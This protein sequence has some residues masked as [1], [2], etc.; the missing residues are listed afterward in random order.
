MQIRCWPKTPR[1]R[2]PFFTYKKV[3]IIEMKFLARLS[4][5]ILIGSLIGIVV[6]FM[7]H[8][9]GLLLNALFWFF[10]SLGV[11]SWCEYRLK[12]SRDGK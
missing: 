11:G 8:N 1:D 4:S 3:R 10:I 9:H 7:H 5:G 2:C 12:K 6:S